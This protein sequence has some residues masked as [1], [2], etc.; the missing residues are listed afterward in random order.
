VLTTPWR[1]DSGALT[2]TL[3][4]ARRI[5]GSTIAALLGV[6]WCLGREMDAD[7][8][9]QP[10]APFDTYV[11]S[12]DFQSSKD[13]L[14]EASEI[15][16]GL[17]GDDPDFH[18]DAQATVIR[19][20]TGCAMHALSCSPAACRGKTGGVVADEVPFWRRQEDMWAAVKSITDPNL[21][22]ATGYPR[23]LVGT[24]WDSGSLAHRLFADGG[25]SHTEFRNGKPFPSSGYPFIRHRI[26]I[27]DAVKSGFP[28]DID[29]AF[30]ELG[31][32]ELIDTEYKC[33]W[34]G[35]NE[36]FFSLEKLR[37]THE[38]ALPDYWISFPAFFG[39]DVGGAKGRDNT[40]IVQWR[41]TGTDLWM[42]GVRAWNKA[43]EDAEEKLQWQADQIT[44]W[45]LA[46]TEH[47]TP[48]TIAVDRGI[49]GADLIESVRKRLK[50]KRH[51]VQVIGVGM[52]IPEQASYAKAARKAL[53]RGRWHIY[54]GV[55]AGGE[56]NGAR[57]LELELNSL[58]TRPG[59]G[60]ILTFITP[61]DAT[62]R[63]RDRAWAALIG[64]S[65]AVKAPIE[66]AEQESTTTQK[67]GTWNANVIHY[68][69]PLGGI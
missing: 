20:K 1:N 62:M 23:I 31:I 47:S 65:R 14:K 37:R 51:N 53:D 58:K 3:E 52:G 42:V 33:I 28:I 27:Y 57:A 32:P 16:A 17:E 66:A 40:S 15:C 59:D 12:K 8:N 63:H 35:S 39:I 29:K 41:T 24:P 5:G 34:R 46:C 36:T 19:F 6:L 7:G 30:A 55:D 10:R 48:I 50:N 21:G 18:S 38:D 60:G 44:E 64:V 4:K 25:V 68:H 22:E 11:I 54:L 13:I 2:Q 49:M 45:I 43:P 9:F 26:D 67:D 56:E 61:R 69:S